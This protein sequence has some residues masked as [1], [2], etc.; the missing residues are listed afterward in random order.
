MVAEARKK[1]DGSVKELSFDVRDAT[2]TGYPDA[3]F[4][5][6]V[7]ANAL[8]IVP[9]P[10]AVLKEIHR[11]LKPGGRLFAPTFVLNEGKGFR[12]FVKLI[13]L[14]GFKA[15]NKWN[16]DEL[17]SFVETGG[18]RMIGHRLMKSGVSPLAAIEAV[19]A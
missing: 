4:D 16:L 12:P 17:V 9:D 6:V 11:I 2:A 15:F 7:I 8:H 5:V 13:S 18:F 19:K 1:D 3:S 14:F 10:E